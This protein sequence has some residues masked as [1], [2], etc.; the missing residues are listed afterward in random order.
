MIAKMTEYVTNTVTNVPA[1]M[2]S[3]ENRVKPQLV[4]LTELTSIIEY[5][6]LSMYV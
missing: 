3:L 4:S 2:A 6:I 1:V 5:H